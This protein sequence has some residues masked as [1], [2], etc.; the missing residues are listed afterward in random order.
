MNKAK[1]YTRG[2]TLIALVITVI[3]L[4]ILAGVTIAGLSGDN[5]ILNRAKEAKEKTASAQ[6]IELISMALH[7]KQIDDKLNV[8]EKKLEN[9]ISEKINGTNVN[10]WQRNENFYYISLGNSKEI[11]KVDDNTIE[12]IEIDLFIN[13]KADLKEF[14]ESVN[15]GN[16]YDSKNIYLTDDINL[17]GEEWISIGNEESKFKGHFFENNFSIRN[18]NINNNNSCVG[19]FS[20]NYGEIYGVN[21]IDCSI[22][23]DS[24]I[25]GITGKNFGSIYNCVTTG[26]IHG[27]ERIAGICGAN[28]N[29]VIKG[30]SNEA[31][32]IADINNGAGI[33][34]Q[35]LSGDIS[36]CGNSG[37]INTKGIQTGGIIA[38]CGNSIIS[39]CYN[40]GTVIGEGNY[41][42]G[43]I[44][45]PY[46]EDGKITNCYNIGAISGVQYV[47]G[48]SGTSKR[49]IENCYNA[50]EIIASQDNVG[51]ITGL[52]YYGGII[53]NCYNV[54]DIILNNVSHVGGI[55]GTSGND[56]TIIVNCYNAANISGKDS[57]GGI[58]ASKDGDIRNCGYLKGTT[59]SEGAKELESISSFL[60][61][62][63]GEG[64][65]KQNIENEKHPL[66]IWE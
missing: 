18:M 30:C 59:P 65:F 34:G 60:D 4:L 25:G 17:D 48:I 38:G 63:N 33:V 62:V 6:N 46:G 11:Y 57:Y 12:R 43:I 9:Y 49:I 37:T 61:I 66:L 16:N 52:N 27:N 51:G 58:T 3:V 35:N 28:E 44:G 32:V 31:K 20:E 56:K 54:R 53:R 36:Q 13:N 41:V 5:G 45:N 29:G 24:Y 7:E 40:K 8:N 2:I 22:S 23:A 10:A 26:T 47:G 21:I 64:K 19:L 15:S 50:G 42:G 39:S 1:K 14:R 55:A